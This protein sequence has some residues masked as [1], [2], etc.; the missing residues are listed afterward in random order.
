[1]VSGRS[2]PLHHGTVVGHG[3]SDGGRLLA[4]TLQLIV[5]VLT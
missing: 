5:V 3:V 1:M 2:E 4:E